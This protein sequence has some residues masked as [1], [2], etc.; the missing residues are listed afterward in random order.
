VQTTQN[1]VQQLRSAVLDIFARFPP[2]SEHLKAY[3]KEL[4]EVCMRVL[5][6][7]NEENATKAIKIVCDLYKMHRASLENSVQQFFDCVATLY[8]RAPANVSRLLSTGGGVRVVGVATTAGAASTGTKVVPATTSGSGTGSTAMDVVETKETKPAIATQP[9]AAA[10]ATATTAGAGAGA[11]TSA[12]AAAAA[13]P[14]HPLLLASNSFKVLAEC[15]LAVMQVFHAHNRFIAK[16]VPTLLPVMLAFVEINYVKAPPGSGSATKGAPSASSSSPPLS[17]YEQFF[18]AQV[19][20]LSFITYLLKSYGTL[21]RGK[22]NMICGRLVDLLAECPLHNI[23]SRKELVV[24]VRHSLGCDS[25]RGFIPYLDRLLCGSV[26]VGPSCH[27]SMRPQ[28]YVFCSMFF[29]PFLVWSLPLDLL[30]PAC[31]VWHYMTRV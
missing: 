2:S 17:N 18:S 26:L 4:N 5:S 29:L 10:A 25:K 12:A 19:K 8:G 3:V 30:L 14:A 21:M 1:E 7:D 22:E 13:A 20:T 16:V 24:A 23:S 15:P 9:P 28:T 6:N 27:Q 31:I 11:T